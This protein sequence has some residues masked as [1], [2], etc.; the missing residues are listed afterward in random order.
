MKDLNFLKITKE[1]E[2][3]FKE[4]AL[5]LFQNYA[6]INHESTFRF[7]DVEFYWNSKTHQ[8]NSTYKRKYVEPNNGEWFFHYSGVDIALRNNETG[9]YGG[10]LI[11]EIYDINKKEF[12]RGPMVCYMKLF[13]GTDAFSKSIKT[14]IIEKEFGLDS[15]TPLIR[16]NLRENAKE[17]GK[18]KAKYRFK[19][20]F[21]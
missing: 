20:N 13:S 5:R 14:Q 18:D 15:I 4:I 7:V 12:Y 17:T 1:N 16:V 3:E 10:I 21:K 11:R 6:I 19:A 8:D 9:G 2:S